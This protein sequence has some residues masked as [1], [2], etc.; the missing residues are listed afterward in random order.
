MNNIKRITLDIDTKDIIQVHNSIQTI[1]NQGFTEKLEILPSSG[2]H[3][4]HIIA[5]S[6]TGV[7][8]EQLLGIRAK[9]GDDPIRIYL[10]SMSGRMIQ[11]LFDSKKKKKLTID[12]MFGG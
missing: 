7:N 9:A 5:W 8:K 1:K 4:Y 6:K 12:K 10:D 11:V 3:G 2:G